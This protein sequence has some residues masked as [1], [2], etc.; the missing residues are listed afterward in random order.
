MSGG[1]RASVVEAISSPSFAFRDARIGRQGR[2]RV[3]ER[4]GAR[5]REP[6]LGEEALTRVERD[7]MAEADL[8]GEAGADEDA[9][10]E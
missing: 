3:R 5:E 2:R 4:P 1:S 10:S 9:V 6:A 8:D 7:R